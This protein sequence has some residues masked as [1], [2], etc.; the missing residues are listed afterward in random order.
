[1]SEYQI[2]SKFNTLKQA[3]IKACFA[4][5]RISALCS[6]E[7]IACYQY[8]RDRYADDMVLNMKASAFKAVENC[9]ETNCPAAEQ[10]KNKIK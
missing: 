1:M 3:L 7:D 4:V 6:K 10:C 5:L 2:Q 8:Y 9:S